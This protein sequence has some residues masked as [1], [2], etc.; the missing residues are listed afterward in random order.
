M[1]LIKSRKAFKHSGTERP[2][3]YLAD[4]TATS[5]HNY[6]CKCERE[7]PKADREKNCQGLS[8]FTSL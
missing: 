8:L 3:L 2:K 1:K 4:L 7:S 5:R 6:H